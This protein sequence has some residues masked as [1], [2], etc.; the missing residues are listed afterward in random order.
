MIRASGRVQSPFDAGIHEFRISQSYV[1]RPVCSH[2]ER[3]AASSTYDGL[4]A[5][6]RHSITDPD[7]MRCGRFD[8]TPTAHL[9]ASG[10]IPGDWLR[11]GLKPA[12]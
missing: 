5:R 2:G 10:G 11:Q 8:N 3:F 9:T 12:S 6:T 4:W 7:S 1:L